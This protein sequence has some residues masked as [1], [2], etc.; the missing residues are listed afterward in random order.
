[1]VYIFVC[2][3]SLLKP[4]RYMIKLIMVE[5]FVF[6]FS[7]VALHH[8]S[9]QSSFP[10]WHFEMYL[11]NLSLSISLFFPS[12]PFA[13]QRTAPLPP[14][15]TWAISSDLSASTNVLGIVMFSVVLGTTIGKMQA[16]G[17]PLQDFLSALS[18]AMMIITSWVI[19][20][21]SCFIFYVFS[22]VFSFF[23]SNTISYCIFSP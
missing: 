22:P 2:T 18:E 13:C 23:F 4:I 11:L 20:Y 9:Q 14:L 6:F 15:E 10:D 8:Y 19:W 1:M 5:V 21:V 3:T 7:Y 17:K 12:V 16:R